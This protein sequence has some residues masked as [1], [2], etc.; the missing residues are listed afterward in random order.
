MR[1]NSR[2]EL[3]VQSDQFFTREQLPKPGSSRIGSPDGIELE[4]L[5]RDVV[6]DRNRL[7]S[8]A[9]GE[10]LNERFETRIIS[11]RIPKKIQ[12]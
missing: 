11:Q 12:A 9:R 1:L 5:N 6:A 10:P 7:T 3:R 8:S 2:C 4:L